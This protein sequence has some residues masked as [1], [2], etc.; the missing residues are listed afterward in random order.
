MLYTPTE[1]KAASEA[2][3]KD[4]PT[5]DPMTREWMLYMLNHGY[6]FDGYNEDGLIKMKLPVTEPAQK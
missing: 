2:F 4:V 5:L 1:F 3:E 6:K